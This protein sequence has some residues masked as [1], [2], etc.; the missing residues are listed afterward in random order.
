MGSDLCQ[1]SEQRPVIDAYNQTQARALQ[2]RMRGKT[3]LQKWKLIW[4][5]LFPSDSDEDIPE[6]CK[7]Q[8]HPPLP[9]YVRD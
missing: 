2:D 5:I 7:Q 1:P 3:D 4:R 8:L 6:P 9:A